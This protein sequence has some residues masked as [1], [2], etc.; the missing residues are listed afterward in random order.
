MKKNILIAL[1]LTMLTTS[2]YGA[3]TGYDTTIGKIED[4]LYGFQYNSENMTS[5]LNRVEEAVY[6]KTYSNKT[7]KE[8]LAKL[9]IDLSAKE[10][11][12][13]IPPVEDTF[14]ENDAYIAEDLQETSDVSYP[15]IDE[16]EQQVFKE[17]YTKENIKNRLAKLE[18]K[19]FNKTFNDDLNTRTERLKAELKPKSFMDNRMAQSSNVFYDEDVEP[20]QSNYHLDKFVPPGSFDYEYYNDQ[21]RRLGDYYDDNL[22]SNK[23]HTTKKASIST[24]EKKLY[25]QTFAGDTTENRLARLE[26]SM[27]GTQFTNDDTQTRINR[28]SSAY[29]AEKSAGKYDSNKFTQNLAT[30]MQIGTL[31]LMVLACIL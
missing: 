13:E 6:G 19:T 16:M 11:G 17:K 22:S 24:I 14:A 21:N 30:A 10:M 15:I 29:Q 9:S 3:A 8:R 18:Q 2:A 26:N 5:R 4:S 7:E 28:I 12:N 25:H 1:I 27:F 23:T 31:I 20:V